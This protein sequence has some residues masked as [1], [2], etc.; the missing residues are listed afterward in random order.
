MEAEP[1]RLVVWALA[2][3]EA[4][5]G[6]DVG[7]ALVRTG[8]CESESTELEPAVLV[9]AALRVEPDWAAAT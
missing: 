3:A 6:I 1:V 4:L 8:V 5:A 9:G 2:K 7:T